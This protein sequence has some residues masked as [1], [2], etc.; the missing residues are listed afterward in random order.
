[1]ARSV[2]ASF[3]LNKSLMDFLYS[4]V[5]T[6][7]SKQFL[8]IAERNREALEAPMLGFNY[9]GEDYL[10]TVSRRKWK[11]VDLH[12]T[13]RPEM[14]ALLKMKEELSV[15]MDYVRSYISRVLNSSKNIADYF[16]LL[17]TSIHE[18]LKSCLAV[19]PSSKSELTPDEIADVMKHNQKGYDLVKTRLLKN[20]LI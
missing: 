3:A 5:L 12:E 1:M 15:E 19:M 9:K 11:P 4:K 10:V 7:L 16:V 2:T 13:L 18:G 8:D 6:Y 14:D 17:P 20:M